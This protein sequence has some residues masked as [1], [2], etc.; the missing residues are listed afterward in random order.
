MI[1][2]WINH[3]SFTRDQ[4]LIVI[5]YELGMATIEQLA[6]ITGYSSSQ[7]RWSIQRIR[8][9][10][11]DPYLKRPSKDA[12]MEEKVEYRRRQQELHEAREQWL[13]IIYPQRHGKRVYTLGKKGI[14]YAADMKQ[15]E[16][17]RKSEAST[18]QIDH[19][20]GIN[21][22][23]ARVTREKNNDT[24]IQWSN[25]IEA[26]DNLERYLFMNNQREVDRKM[27]IKPDGQLAIDTCAFWVEYDNDTERP[28]PVERKMLAY[29]ATL[30][31]LSDKHRFPVVWVSP[32]Q[33][34]TDQL[35][36]IWKALQRQIKLNRT[37]KFIPEMHFFTAGEELKYLLG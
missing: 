25:T 35:Q 30:E 26:L 9:Y 1:Q 10:E 5:L 15:E 24:I 20:M 33:K 28:K 4:Q 8:Q 29:Q 34:R 32:H 17:P 6:D 12:P 11:K 7:I 13:R 21:N 27:L 23:L 18:G 14:R 2:A 16:Q 3:P 37:N 31:L 22:I 19:Y 36:A